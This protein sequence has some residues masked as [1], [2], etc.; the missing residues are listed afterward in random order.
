[1]TSTERDL[2]PRVP[3]IFVIAG[4]KLCTWRINQTGWGWKR[5]QIREADSYGK[6]KSTA[7]SWRG[8]RLT[9]LD[10]SRIE[11]ILM[12]SSRSRWLECIFAYQQRPWS[13]TEP[14]REAEWRHE[15]ERERDA[16]DQKWASKRRTMKEPLDALDLRERTLPPSRL[17][18]YV[19]TEERITP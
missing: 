17:Y 1:M 18:I 13:W 4:K 9:G 8:W 2:G 15:R 7:R 3:T 12:G 10:G 16:A 11:A 6:L 19:A 14:G 5:Q